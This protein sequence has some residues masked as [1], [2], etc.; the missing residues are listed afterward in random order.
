MTQD[1]R[2]N[3]NISGK[4]YLFFNNLFNLFYQI[5][6]NK[7]YLYI[8]KRSAVGA[9][10]KNGIIALINNSKLYNINIQSAENFSEFSE[11]IRQLPSFYDRDIRFWHWFAGVIDGDGNFDIRK[12]QQGI[13]VLKAIRIKLHN[14]DLR[15]LT[16]IQNKLH[17]GRINAVNNKP[18]SLYII[19]TKK[20]IEY[21]IKNL[22]GLI[23]LKVDSF[24][25]AC[26]YI[27]IEYQE[28]NYNIEQN[29]PYFSG[30]IDTDG[31]IVFNYTSNRI[32]CVFEVKKTEYSSK[33]CLDNVIPYVKPSVTYRTKYSTSKKDFNSIC[34]KYQTVKSIVPIYDYFIINRLYCDF[35]FYRVTKIKN[36]IEI[37]HYKYYP[38]ESEEFKLYSRF[39]IN[40]IQHINPQWTKTPFVKKLNI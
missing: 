38:F 5:W 18:H 7:W 9:V 25:K 16:Y 20:E 39:I 34:F 14:R 3:L 29:D 37:R 36:F 28:A 26:K 22:N 33:L 13:Y 24:R 19:S 32:E 2:N 4:F 21:V 30:L 31:S 15:L 11:T 10:G 12:K 40:W 35:K 1:L 17:I 23:R 27:D 8:L 6:P